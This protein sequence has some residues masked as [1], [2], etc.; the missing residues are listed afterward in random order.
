MLEVRDLHAGWGKTV[1]VQGVSISAN[2]GECLSV[3]GRNG[4]GKT[5]LFEAIM[6]RAN[7][8]AG[9][10]ILDGNDI[11]QVDT[12]RKA[13]AGLGY[14]PQN[15]EV[16]KSLTVIEHLEVGRRTGPWDA[17]AVF[18]VFPGLADRRQSLGAVLSGGE[19]QMLAIGRAL[20]GNPR[21]L[22]L[23]EPTEGLSPLIVESLVQSIRE[24]LRHGMAV[25]LVE[26]HLEVAMALSD[27]CVVMDRGQTVYSGSADDL[28]QRRSEVE[29]LIG[30]QI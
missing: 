21:V 6:G 25:L 18:K 11:T 19:Q 10:V 17:A 7:T 24:I 30:V 4:V 22:L 2:F 5:T 14:V 12:Y 29:M 23:D 9:S 8:H 15:R 20:V 13:R 26:Q 16:F 3:I 1:V 27:K 28:K